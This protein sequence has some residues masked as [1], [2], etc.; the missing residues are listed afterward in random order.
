[1]L[2]AGFNRGHLAQGN[3]EQQKAELAR[4]TVN[5]RIGQP[6]EIASVIYFLADSNQSGY[7]TGQSVVV[8]GGASARL[9]TE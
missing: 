8:D 4:K 1:M 6:H 3:V 7:M 2:E 5:G 9:S